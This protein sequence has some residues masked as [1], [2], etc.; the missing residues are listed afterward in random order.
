MVHWHINIRT[1]IDNKPYS[2]MIHRHIHVRTYI[3]NKPYSSKP[4]SVT[5]GAGAADPG[6]APELIPLFSGVCVAR[7]LFSCVVLCR[8]LLVLLAIVLSVLRFTYFYYSFYSFK[9]FR[10]HEMNTDIFLQS[11]RNLQVS[12]LLCIN[13]WPISFNAHIKEVKILQK[14]CLDRPSYVDFKQFPWTNVSICPE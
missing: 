6:V 3:D 2:T 1:Y 5:G 11:L 8:S 12:I 7:Y 4:T 14:Y 10:E 13:N 9:P